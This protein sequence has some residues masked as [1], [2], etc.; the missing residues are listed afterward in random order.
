MPP[1]PA[2]QDPSFCCYATLNSMVARSLGSGM[3]GSWFVEDEDEIK[4]AASGGVASGVIYVSALL[5]FCGLLPGVY[6]DVEALLA[7]L[8]ENGWERCKP[9][10]LKAIWAVTVWGS[11]TGNQHV[12]F[13]VPGKDYAI[14]CLP[15]PGF[16]LVSSSV[17]CHGLVLD[18][19]REIHEK[20]THPRLCRPMPQMAR[21]R[22]KRS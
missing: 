10:S 16:P 20:W 18:D 1:Q 3:F 7:A 11:E 14:S 8:K 12:G 6:T 15:S 19:G 4:D 22:G 2:N 9:N 21:E 13:N 5:T 17:T